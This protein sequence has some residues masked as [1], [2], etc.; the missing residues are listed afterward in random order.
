MSKD[1]AEETKG[2]G[3]E[4]NPS[5]KAKLLY[6]QESEIITPHDVLDLTPPR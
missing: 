3:I 6:H 2:E 1:I 5:Q 4:L